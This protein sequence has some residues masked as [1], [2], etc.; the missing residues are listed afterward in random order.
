MLADLLRGDKMEDLKENITFSRM[1]PSADSLF[2]YG[3]NKGTLKM[4]DM[5]LSSNA[6]SSALSFTA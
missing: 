4:C 6:D 3:T 1:H 2:V 5:R